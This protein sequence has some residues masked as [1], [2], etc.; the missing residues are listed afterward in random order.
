[1]YRVTQSRCKNNGNFG[2][3]LVWLSVSSEEAAKGSF[4]DLQ[5]GF[6]HARGN[7]LHVLDICLLS[8][9]IVTFELANV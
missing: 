5:A 3:D 7:K 1:M 2:V 6:P 4:L 9:L 8:N